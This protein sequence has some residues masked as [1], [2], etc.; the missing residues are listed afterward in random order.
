MLLLKERILGDVMILDVCG[1]IATGAP[2]V[3]LRDKVRS[4]LYRGHRKVLLNLAEATS[5]D[6]SGVSAFLG[7]LLDARDVGAEL[8]LLHVTARIDDVRILVALYRYF[9]VFDSEIE[10]VAS[11]GAERA[12]PEAGAG[13][14]LEPATV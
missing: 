2:E 9:T 8:R 13:G 6:A 7:A 12:V 5:S 3:E 14:W 4:I 11:F 10:G 1:T